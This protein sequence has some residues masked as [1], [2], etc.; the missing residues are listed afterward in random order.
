FI[1]VLTGL[2][3][4]PPGNPSP[5]PLSLKIP[6]PST[7]PP[8][9]SIHIRLPAPSRAYPRLFT[10]FRFCEKLMKAAQVT[11]RLEV[12]QDVSVRKLILVGAA[13]LSLSLASP[14]RATL[15]LSDSFSY[16]NGPLVTVSGGA[17]IHHS[18][19]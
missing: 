11:T 8:S 15:L 12:R 14:T 13:T 17:W 19:T 4:Y 7:P 5:H 10:L 6:H 3:V 18:G 2:R 1:G 9:Q 16:T